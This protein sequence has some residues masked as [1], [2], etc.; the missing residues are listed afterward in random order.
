MKC[1]SREDIER[2]KKELNIKSDV[3]LVS[4][5]SHRALGFTFGINRIRDYVY[6]YGKVTSSTSAI[7]VMFYELETGKKFVQ[8]NI[9]TN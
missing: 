1:L 4:R 2:I 9:T 5:V 7:L 8:N 6:S 3:E